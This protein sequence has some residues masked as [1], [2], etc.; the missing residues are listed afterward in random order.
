MAAKKKA[1]KKK[2]SP[3]KKSMVKR[4]GSAMATSKFEER[5]M[6]AAQNDA[7]RTGASSETNIM[8]IRGGK[9]TFQGEN[10]GNELKLI[11]LGHVYSKEYYDGKFDPDNP[12]PPACFA[13]SEDMKL[14]KGPDGTSPAPQADL[15]K[16]CEQNEW[17]S[18]GFGQSK[19]CGAKVTFAVLDPDGATDEDYEH[20]VMRVGVNSMLNF[21]KYVKGLSSKLNLPAFGVVTNVVFDEESTNPILEFSL[22]EV[23]DNEEVLE[24]LFERRE[25]L[26]EEMLKP[27]FDVDSYVPPEEREPKRK[28]R[29]KKGSLG[30]KKGAAKKKG[31]RS[32]FAR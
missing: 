21:D 20:A 22:D 14:I 15:C 10:L 17:G 24:S 19:A 9:F 30:K 11:I 8:S 13:L 27:H 5:M 25:G 26:I 4:K 2:A 32:K 12:V 31:G 16:D 28:S 1:S 23:I 6:E 7:A 29:K 3:K 18:S